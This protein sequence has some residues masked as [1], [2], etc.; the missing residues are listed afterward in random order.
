MAAP[1]P[2][3]RSRLNMDDEEDAQIPPPAAAAPPDQLEP[4]K[5]VYVLDQL[6]PE[7]GWPDKV[8][9]DDDIGAAQLEFIGLVDDIA[10]RTQTYMG[11]AHSIDA[12]VCDM[13]LWVLKHYISNSN[14]SPRLWINT[15]NMEGYNPFM[16][17]FF[18]TPIYTHRAIDLTSL[19][20]SRQLILW[21]QEGHPLVS[22]KCMLTQLL[23][24]V[25]NFCAGTRAL[26]VTKNASLPHS[27]NRL[28]CFLIY[29]QPH[30]L[31]DI[32]VFIER[33]DMSSDVA[34]SARFWR[35]HGVNK[36]GKLAPFVDFHAWRS[37]KF[38]MPCLSTEI[39]D[40]LRQFLRVTGSLQNF[41]IVMDPL[42]VVERLRSHCGTARLI[43]S[44]PDITL[45]V[46]EMVKRFGA[47]YV[48]QGAI[49]H[50]YT[51]AALKDVCISPFLMAVGCEY[52]KLAPGTTNVIGMALPKRIV[53]LDMFNAQRWETSI[54][55]FTNT[56]KI[57]LLMG[58]HPRIGAASAI[59][60]SLRQRTDFEPK[61]L[62]LVFGFV[63]KNVS[64]L[65][66]GA[67]T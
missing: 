47:N 57:A 43:T 6:N 65:V 67:T 58:L 41:T 20:A 23:K 36:L 55:D 9:H 49:D 4:P 2:L 46:L 56:H 52:I 30:T 15:H 64:G 37:T 29:D 45:S 54:P 1:P 60:R 33:Y 7:G 40:T 22:T 11:N 51:H 35:T 17:I 28:A 31:H 44:H 16:Y 38:H 10:R 18:N 62:Q 63:E 26:A 12:F 61:V 27:V 42:T 24:R 5:R 32:N 39:I 25:W 21:Y 34:W 3:K 13:H 48:I 66:D 14:N 59:S 19:H 50:F 53:P 8:V